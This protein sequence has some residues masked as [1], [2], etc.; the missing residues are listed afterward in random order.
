M[1]RRWN[2]PAMFKGADRQFR[3]GFFART[4]DPPLHFAQVLRD[5]FEVR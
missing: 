2:L 1:K 3:S 4:L 5:Q